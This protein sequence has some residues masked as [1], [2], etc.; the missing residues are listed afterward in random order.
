M[1]G[2]RLRGRLALTLDDE[3]NVDGEV[4][5]DALDL[6]PAFALAIGAQGHDAT[7]PLGSGL[8]KGWRG[9][10]AFQ[11]LRGQLPGGG[12]LRPVSGTRQ[13][14]RPIADLR[15]HQGRHRRRRGDRHDRRETRRRM[16]LRSMRA[17]SSA[18]SMARRC[19]IARW[20]CPRAATSMQMTLA[21]QGRSASALTGALVRQRNRDAGIRCYHGSRSARLRCRDPRQ[22]RRPG[23]RRYPAAARSSSRYLSGGALSVAS[24][25]IPFTIRDGRLAR[26]RDHARF[27]SRPRHHFR[28]IRYSGR[29]GRYSRRQL[30]RRRSDQRA[31]ARKSSCSRRARPMRSIAPSTW[32]RCRH[33]WR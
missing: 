16:V 20:R 3:S 24:A 13:E 27:R 12:E 10:I 6:A 17:F 28:R 32:R 33:G 25:Q 18:A 2:S 26:R 9:R 4:G 31:A 23:D 22:R 11:A 1:S 15:H 21:S 5:L 8:L 30:P 29:S 14:R 19:I 7:E